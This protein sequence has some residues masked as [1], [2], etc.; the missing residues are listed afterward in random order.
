MLGGHY[1]ESETVIKVSPLSSLSWLILYRKGWF[2]SK[3]EMDYLRRETRYE[4]PGLCGARR[5]NL[6]GITGNENPI[7]LA[8]DM[9]AFR[10]VY[11]STQG[12]CEVDILL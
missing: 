11:I 9:S 3:R 4:S 8:Q 7:D 1:D 5:Q 12:S 10:Q 6:S 2:T